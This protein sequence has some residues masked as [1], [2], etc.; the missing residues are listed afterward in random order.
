MEVEEHTLKKHAVRGLQVNKR[1]IGQ[2][3]RKHRKAALNPPEDARPTFPTTH[4]KPQHQA[5]PAFPTVACC[6][7]HQETA[8]GW[9]SGWVRQPGRAGCC[10]S[11]SSWRPSG[12]STG[13]SSTPGAKKV[14]GEVKR[15]ERGKA[16]ARLPYISSLTE[17][18][19]SV[20]T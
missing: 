14:D 6:R 7:G 4:E 12:A 18:D 17:E 20:T 1:T 15:G 5:C 8:F 13:P 9:P 16:R 11:A 19:N 2:T 3:N 10:L